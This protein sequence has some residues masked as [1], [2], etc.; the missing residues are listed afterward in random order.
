M[1]HIGAMAVT[2]LA[3]FTFSST[4]SSAGR[5]TR[6]SK[7]SASRERLGVTLGE[8]DSPRTRQAA[9]R[10]PRCEAVRIPRRARPLPRPDRIVETCCET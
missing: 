8:Y 4:A 7:S 3:A 1:S 5:L 2:P 9:V 6:H 10:P